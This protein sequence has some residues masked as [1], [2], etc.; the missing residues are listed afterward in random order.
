MSHKIRAGIG[1]AGTF[2]AAGLISLAT[3]PVAHAVVSLVI[4]D[5]FVARHR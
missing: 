1:I 4:A 2:L 5:S 3:G